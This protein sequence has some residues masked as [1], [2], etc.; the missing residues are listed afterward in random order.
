[1]RLLEVNIGTVLIDNIDLA[2]M[3]SDTLRERLFVIPQE[4][5]TLSSTLRRNLDPQ[6]TAT[7]AALITVLTRVGLHDLLAGSRGLD[8]HVTATTLS[9][10]Q[11][12]LLALARLLLKK[13]TGTKAKDRGVLLL[14]EAT[15]H[16][17]QA[18][19]TVL[20]RIVRE[21]FA[22]FTV[23]AVAHRLNTILDS[24][25]VIVMDAG[26]V[27]EVGPPGDLIEKGRWFVQLVQADNGAKIPTV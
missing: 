15:S 11:Q 25:V 6:N 20:Q 23:I 9:A 22:G 17:D 5:L 18:A 16:V 19:E 12:Q 8:A 7:D 1:M 14:D 13:G 2:T 4:S 26:R 24:D 3:S 21:E 27:V 10:G